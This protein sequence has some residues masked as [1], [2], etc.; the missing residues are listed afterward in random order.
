MT[1]TQREMARPDPALQNRPDPFADIF[2][3]VDPGL[4]RCLAPKL[5][6]IE[7]GMQAKADLLGLTIALLKFLR[8]PSVED[9]MTGKI[10]RFMHDDGE[11]P[12]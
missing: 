7:Q 3:G 4:L 11:V 10:A 5:L 1:D 6:A 12:K 2:V 8:L 9:G